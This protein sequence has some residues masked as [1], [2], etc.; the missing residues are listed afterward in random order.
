MILYCII[1]RGWFSCEVADK[2]Y[3]MSV[4]WD[5]GPVMV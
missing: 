2:V 5:G 4:T 1:K 3:V